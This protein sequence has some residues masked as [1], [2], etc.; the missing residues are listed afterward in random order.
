[1]QNWDNAKSAA[2]FTLNLIERKAHSARNEPRGLEVIAG[3]ETAKK[4]YRCFPKKKLN[5]NAE[6]V[7]FIIFGHIINES[8]AIDIS[9]NS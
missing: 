2:L 5:G 6:T 7:N 4:N 3:L 9:V 1:M 8:P